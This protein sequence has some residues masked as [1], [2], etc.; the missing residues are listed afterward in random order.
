ME[1]GVALFHYKTFSTIC[2]SGGGGGPDK[3]EASL[4]MTVWT[5]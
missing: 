1:A 4:R 3:E 5:H 2:S